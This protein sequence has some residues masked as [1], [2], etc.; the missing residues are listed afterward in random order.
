[1]N[2]LIGLIEYLLGF[3]ALTVF[4]ALAFAAAPQTNATWRHAFLVAGAIACVELAV[5]AYRAKPANRFIIGA[6]V[7][8]IV[9]AVAFLSKQWWLLAIYERWQG[10]GLVGAMLA[11]GVLTSIFSSAGFVGAYGPKPAVTLTSVA[12]LAATAC[13]LWFVWQSREP[14]Q[15][16]MVAPLVML[17]LLNRVLRVWMIKR[18]KAG[19]VGQPTPLIQP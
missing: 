4:A 10:I 1:V 17:A 14:P 15:S 18:R 11:V 6:N 19:A 13:V 12:L 9:G 7:W 16:A 5:L 2:R 3:I 8:L